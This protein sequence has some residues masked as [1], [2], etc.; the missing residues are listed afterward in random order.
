MAGTQ[1][2]HVPDAV[3]IAPYLIVPGAV[4]LVLLLWARRRGASWTQVQLCFAVAMFAAFLTASGWVF[5]A[6]VSGE[7]ISTWKVLG[8]QVLVAGACS[9]LVFF[10]TM[11]VERDLTD[12]DDLHP[13]SRGE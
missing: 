12:P 5:A 3:T 6:Y 8:S 2:D 10:G 9:M 13:D 7:R 1:Y 11:P 4:A